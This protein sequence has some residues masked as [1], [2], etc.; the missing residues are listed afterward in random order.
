MLPLTIGNWPRGARWAEAGVHPCR[1][2]TMVAQLL[3]LSKSE[4]A[5]RRN[6]SFFPSR[7]VASCVLEIAVFVR[8]A[9]PNYV[10]V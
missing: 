9:S 8:N 5:A 7:Q 6:D 1:R 10:N 2:L 3:S 4:V